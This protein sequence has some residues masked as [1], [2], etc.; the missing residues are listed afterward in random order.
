MPSQAYQTIETL[1]QNNSAL[2]SMDL[3]ST[4]ILALLRKI[5]QPELKNITGISEG[6]EY[7]LAKA[8]FYKAEI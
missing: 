2:P 4:S 5:K 6:L 8:A 3:L 7:K 1:Y